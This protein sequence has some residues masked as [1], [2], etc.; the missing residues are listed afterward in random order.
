MGDAVRCQNSIERVG[1]NAR[2][3]RPGNLH[4]SIDTS[5]PEARIMTARS[6]PARIA[7]ARIRHLLDRDDRSYAERR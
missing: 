3:I 4:N 1:G 6:V 2:F 7:Q 5:P